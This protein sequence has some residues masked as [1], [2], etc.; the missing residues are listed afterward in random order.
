M[1]Q[2]RHAAQAL[3]ERGRPSPHLLSRRCILHIDDRHRNRQIYTN[4]MLTIINSFISKQKVP[5]D[6]MANITDQIRPQRVV[7][8]R[9]GEYDEQELANFPRLFEM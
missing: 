1:Y 6:I 8:K 5:D 9:L 4:H 7:P 2:D 3:Q